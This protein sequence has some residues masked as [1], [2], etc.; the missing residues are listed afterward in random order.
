MCVNLSCRDVGA[1]LPSAATRYVELPHDPKMCMA[2]IDYLQGTI[3]AYRGG[4][5][6]AALSGHWIH[7][8]ECLH[9]SKSDIAHCACG[10]NSRAMES[11][12]IAANEWARHALDVLAA[13][14]KAR[15]V[16]AEVVSGPSAATPDT[17]AYVC[18]FYFRPDGV[19]LIRKARPEWQRGKLNGVGGHIEAGETPAE[20]MRREFREETGAD[21]EG[22]AHFATLSG[23]RWAVHFFGAMAVDD[24]PV[25]TLTDEDVTL[26]DWKKLGDDV[27][28]NLHYLI[29]MYLRS[30]R[31][32]WP[33]D[34]RESAATR[35]DAT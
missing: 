11:V 10:W 16:G 3:S 18:G 6:Q 4:G 5:A 30:D 20:A 2:E 22:W 31:K 32:F 1:P 28:P 24:R 7:Q 19:V 23:N 12:G 15:S 27:I 34:I 21:V 33:Q 29:P 14:V 17:Q 25:A 8:M 26:V 9:E 35:E 13:Y